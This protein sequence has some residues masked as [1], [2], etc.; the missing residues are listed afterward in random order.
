MKYAQPF[1]IG[2]PD[3]SYINGDPSQARMGSIPPAAS[4][5]PKLRE[6][7]AVIEDSMIVPTSDDLE[8]VTKGV[9]SQRMNYVEDSGTTNQLT[10]ALDPPLTS[11]TIGLPL[12]VKVYH[13]NT[14][15]ATIDAGAGRVSIRKP[16][17]AEVGAGDL[18]AAGLVELVYDGTFFEMVNFG[19][20]N[21]VGTVTTVYTNIP[22]TVDIST[23]KNTIIANFTPA[24]KTYSAGLIF[25]V[26]V[27][28]TNNSFANINVN[29]LGLRPVY[30][31]G[32]HADWPLLPGDMQ[33]GDVLLFFYDGSTFWINPNN[34]INED[35][36]VNVANPIQFDAIF[37]ALSRKRISPSATVTIMLGAGRWAKDTPTLNYP[38]DY[39]VLR[40]YH[41]DADRIVIQGTM[42]P[43]QNP[44]QSADWYGTNSSPEGRAESN[45]YNWLMLLS[46]FGTVIRAGGFQAGIEHV[47]PGS[48]KLKNIF[49]AGYAIYAE[50][51]RGFST[52]NNAQMRCYNCVSHYSGD[53][54]F[55]CDSG[56]MMYLFDCYATGAQ[57]RAF[58]ATGSAKMT[59]VNGWGGLCGQS[60]VESS[61]GAIISMI[62]TAAPNFGGSD[63]T[64]YSSLNAV[65]GVSSQTG[66]SSLY[67]CIIG[68]NGMFDHWA[69][70][71]GLTTFVHSIYHTSTPDL[72]TVGNFNAL[73]YNYG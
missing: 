53:S 11:Y 64:F 2:D 45:Y 60:G 1:G 26:K 17:G 41:L 34:V 49:V 29:G 15:A 70:N 7:V 16:N 9:R 66:L 19:G 8:Q 18:P 67:Y 72:W 48:I 28:N 32:G 14:S 43:G 47:G 68:S 31:Q 10:V 23:V 36:V 51:Q 35:V 12:V 13:T 58:A 62:G 56:G 6:L 55:V 20:G 57:L 59:M 69:L 25:S 42:K 38:F 21:P 44:P 63:D 52:S 50:G 27:A 3:A 73:I 30:A 39:A 24:I 33:V 54:G 71:M 37:S 4:V 46:K 61:H 65:A 5:E 22:Y 40:S